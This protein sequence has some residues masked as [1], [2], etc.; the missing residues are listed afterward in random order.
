MHNDMLVLLRCYLMAKGDDL[1]FHRHFIAGVK[2][3]DGKW[4]N[5]YYNYQKT[6]ASGY[7]FGEKYKGK[8]RRI[9]RG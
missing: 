6:A 5:Y 4:L 3:Q 2:T 8:E 9:L 7:I 1:R